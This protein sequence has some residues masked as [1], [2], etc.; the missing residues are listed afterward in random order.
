MPMYADGVLQAQPVVIAQGSSEAP[1][2]HPSHDSP[3]PPPPRP[4][5]DAP[6]IGTSRYAPSAPRAAV[7]QLASGGPFIT[8][9]LA[10]AGHTLQRPAVHQTS[11]SSPLGLGLPIGAYAQRPIAPLV[12]GVSVPLVGVYISSETSTHHPDEKA[13]PQAAPQFGPSGLGTTTLAAIGPGP[14]QQPGGPAVFGNSAPTSSSGGSSSVLFGLN[15][16]LAAMTLLAGM[17]WR[18]RSWGRP[19][20][21]GESA[22][23]SSALDRPG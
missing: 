7:T 23:L 4:S 20:L 16:M 19:V 17:S 1:I 21:R 15:A 11:P 14:L 18:R 12:V 8:T 5:I 9:G 22:L 6:I 3:T 13:S 10:A 2:G